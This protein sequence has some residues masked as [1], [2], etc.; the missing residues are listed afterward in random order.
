LDPETGQSVAEV[1]SV[2]V[3]APTAMLADALS[4]AAFVLGAERGLDL[5][6][7]QNVEGLIVSPDLQK[8]ETKGLSRYSL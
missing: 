7:S 4:T 6:E 8:F 1:A 2:T 5:L 3:V